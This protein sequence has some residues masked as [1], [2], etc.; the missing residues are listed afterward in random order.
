MEH[1]ELLGRLYDEG[2]TNYGTSEAKRKVEFAVKKTGLTVKQVKRW[3]DNKRRQQHRKEENQRPIRRRRQ[4]GYNVFMKKYI[5]SKGG[6]APNKAMVLQQ[7]AEEWRRMA[8]EEKQ[9]YKDVAAEENKT[10]PNVVQLGESGFRVFANKLC[11]EV[12]D[13]CSR[14]EGVEWVLVCSN[15]S[16]GASA[17]CGSETGVNLATSTCF[18]D[19]LCSASGYDEVT[20]SSSVTPAEYSSK[21]RFKVQEIFNRKYREATGKNK[22]MS[23]QQLE[24]GQIQSTGLP[25]NVKLKRPSAYGKETLQKIIDAES[26]IEFTVS[27]QTSTLA[28]S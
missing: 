7:G 17:V 15:V 18:A 4:S 2:M 9:E 19:Q 5:C 11:K 6:T 22:P 24:A 23:Y 8:E 14:V 10:M 12:T 21:L 16:I 28:Q 20:I 3:I 25:P 1:H 26:A 27:T 13:M